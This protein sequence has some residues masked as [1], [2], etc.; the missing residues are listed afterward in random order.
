[1]DGEAAVTLVNRI[2]RQIDGDAGTLV[3]DPTRD[4]ATTVVAHR[5]FDVEIG[6]GRCE[7][8]SIDLMVGVSLG[9]PPIAR[10]EEFLTQLLQWNH[11]TAGIGHFSLDDNGTVYI[12]SRHGLDDLDADGLASIIGAMTTAARGALESM[13]LAELSAGLVVE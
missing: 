11:C 13:S 12:V 1:M 7:Q 3:F 6:V 10:R 5:G 4:G 9:R 8:G 2:V